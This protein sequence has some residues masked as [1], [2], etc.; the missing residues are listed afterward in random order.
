MAY[1]ASVAPI[2]TAVWGHP[3]RPGRAEHTGDRMVMSQ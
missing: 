3:Y 2:L 1:L